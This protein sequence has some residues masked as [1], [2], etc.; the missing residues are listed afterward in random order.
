MGFDHV[1][2]CAGAGKPTVLDMPNGLA[3]G[4]RTASDFLMALQLTGA[5]KKDSIANLQVRLPVVVIGGGLTAID[6]ATESLAYYPVQ[7][8]K[9]LARYETLVAEH[10]EAAVRGRVERRRARDRRGVHRARP[11][12]PRRARRGGARGPRSPRIAE[13][14]QRLGR[15]HHRLSPPADRFSPSY[16][17]NHEEVEKALEEGIRF[18][19][20][21]TP[22]AVE[23]DGQWR[24]HARS[25]STGQQGGEKIEATAA[26]AHHPGRRRHAAQHR[27]GARG[28]DARLHRRQ[29]LPRARRG[30]RAG[31]AR[32]G[33]QARRGARADVPPRRRPLHDV[34]RRPA[35]V[36]RRQRGEGDGR[37]QAGLSGRDAHAGEARRRRS[38][39]PQRD[40]RRGQQRL[41]RHG[42][43][44][45]AP[46]ADHRRGRGRGA[47]GGAQLRARPVLS[48]AELRGALAEDR[49][50]PARHGRPGADRRLG[51]PGQGPALD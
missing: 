51:R 2:L 4:V 6:T 21:L 14:L 33:L 18:A 3:R 24:R 34:L 46:D 19:E 11:G 36:V 20:G 9:F 5:A 48:P 41:A 12:D 16:T 28:R 45:R 43:A 31:D 8:E 50:H 25:R 26:R 22:L 10:G 13:L 47:G 44:R 17:L 7:V 42:R 40:P 35:S 39:S 49:R 29:V 37:R 30:R 27:A 23:V 15:R 38:R 1:A 32:A